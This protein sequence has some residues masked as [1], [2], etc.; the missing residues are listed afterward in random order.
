MRC[1]RTSG[2]LYTAIEVNFTR[3]RYSYKPSC[4]PNPAF[5]AIFIVLQRYN[6]LHS[7]VETYMSRHRAE[8]AH[9][10]ANSITL[11]FSTQSYPSNN[12]T[13]LCI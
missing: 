7:E 1:Y 9:F 10:T 8:I 4:Q 2:C 13:A 12:K 3:R 5:G 11:T 6:D